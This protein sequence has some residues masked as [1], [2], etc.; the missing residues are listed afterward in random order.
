MVTSALHPVP[1]RP[2]CVH[3]LLDSGPPSPPPP[4]W[5]DL[6]SKRNNLHQRRTPSPVWTII[7]KPS[8]AP[9]TETIPFVLSRPLPFREKTLILI[10][11]GRGEGRSLWSGPLVSHMCHPPPTTQFESLKGAPIV[12]TI[13]Q[14]LVGPTGC[15]RRGRILYIYSI[16]G[17]VIGRSRLVFVGQS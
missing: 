16:P 5:K 15:G 14:R 1:R 7:E 17:N 8:S 3:C 13:L 12:M 2:S 11:A 9:A 6:L 4:R 10:H